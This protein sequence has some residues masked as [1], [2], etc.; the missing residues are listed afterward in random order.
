[1]YGINIKAREVRL[2]FDKNHNFESRSAYTVMVKH[3]VYSKEIKGRCS[4]TFE[5]DTQSLGEDVVTYL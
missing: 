5:F 1:M 2:R 4:S 3:T